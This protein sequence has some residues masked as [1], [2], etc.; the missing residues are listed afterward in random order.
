MWER[1]R[2]RGFELLFP[3]QILHPPLILMNIRDKAKCLMKK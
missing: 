2:V 3:G 1:E